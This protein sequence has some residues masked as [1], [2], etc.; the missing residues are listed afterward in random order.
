MIDRAS[1]L[2]RLD[3]LQDQ[4]DRHQREAL[5]AALAAVRAELEALARGSAATQP[6]PHQRRQAA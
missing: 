6:Q 5:R 3:S 2:E 1:L 4:H